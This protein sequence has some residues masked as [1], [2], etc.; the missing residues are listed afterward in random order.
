MGSPDDGRHY[1]RR[2]RWIVSVRS[3]LE[4]QQQ[5]QMP[6]AQK[7]PHDPSIKM[8]KSN[9]AKACQSCWKH[10][11]KYR[12]L[13]PIC[14][15]L[16]APGCKPEMCWSDELN[17]CKECHMVIGMLKHYRFKAQYDNSEQ[18]ASQSSC[19]PTKVSYA[20][21]PIGVQVNIM[22]FVLQTKDF[23]WSGNY[24]AKIKRSKE[25]MDSPMRTASKACPTIF[26]KIISQV[27]LCD[28]R[29]GNR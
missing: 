23:I 10:V 25:E 2:R 19:A 24:Q 28:G 11:S 12:R 16:I 8:Y 9:R 5:Q 20:D 18:G 14:T 17:H 3:T 1:P 21:F 13:C 7:K 22:R 6:P 27:Y 4:I 15:K 26:P 29:G